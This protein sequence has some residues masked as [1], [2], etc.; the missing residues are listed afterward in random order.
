MFKRFKHWKLDKSRIE[1]FSDG[2]FAI[3]ITLLILE[4]KVPHLTDAANSRELWDKL[5]DIWP[6]IASW[7]VSF[8]FIAVMWV[9]HH[10]LLRM[11]EKVDY[12]LIWINNIFLLLICFLPFPTALMGEYEHNRFAVLLFG[13]VAT[14]VTLAQIWLY[15]YIAMN[16]LRTAYSQAQVLKNVK[17]AF[18]L[19]PFTL[20]VAALLSLVSLVLPYIFYFLVPF[21]FLLPLD[22][23]VDPQS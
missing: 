6:K 18:F 21:F 16:Y 4:I 20:I 19:A 22:E 11:A 1:A 13:F 2:V 15:Y 9:Q 3:I 14:L 5:T 10:N 7:V 23:E 17:R 8:F 12:G